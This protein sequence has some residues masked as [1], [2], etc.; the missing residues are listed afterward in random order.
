MSILVDAEKAFDKIQPYFMIKKSW[1]GQGTYL[2]IKAFSSKPTGV[3]CC[4]YAGEG[5]HKIR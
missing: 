2:K 1:R 5:S 3:D 4:L